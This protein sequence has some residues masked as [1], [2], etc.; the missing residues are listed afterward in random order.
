[1]I[2]PTEFLDVGSKD[3]LMK[4]LVKFFGKKTTK[5]EI[6]EVCQFH[7]KKFLKLENFEKL[8]IFNWAIR[9]IWR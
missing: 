9:K 4:I 7:V 5:N 1:M 8:V 2:S 3:F 6:R